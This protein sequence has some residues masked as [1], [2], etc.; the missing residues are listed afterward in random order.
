MLKAPT[1]LLEDPKDAAAE[2]VAVWDAEAATVTGAGIAE[3]QHGM[4]Y[5]RCEI[6]CEY[7]VP[8][9]PTKVQFCYILFLWTLTKLLVAK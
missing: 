2:M 4:K 6:I 5:S 7:A 9:P 1:A 3:G 8:P